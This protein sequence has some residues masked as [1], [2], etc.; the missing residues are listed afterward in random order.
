LSNRK[1][2]TKTKMKRTNNI[3]KVFLFIIGFSI[4]GISIFAYLE[5]LFGADN[6]FIG[7]LC[8]IPFLLVWCINTD[9]RLKVERQQN[10]ES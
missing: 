1:S 8:S 5:F 10:R 6:V 4:A 7:A 3:L 9:A 2:L